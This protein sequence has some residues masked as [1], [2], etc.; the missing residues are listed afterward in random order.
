MG[1]DAAGRPLPG[2]VVSLTGTDGI[3]RT[4]PPCPR[5]KP[6]AA[7]ATRLGGL[8]PPDSVSAE[9]VLRA[10]HEAGC[11][12]VRAHVAQVLGPEGLDAVDGTQPFAGLGLT[13]VAAPELRE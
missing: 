3:P 9:L 13:T 2:A 8:T 11:D 1:G 7:W 12:L 5:R 6:Q 4:G 10:D